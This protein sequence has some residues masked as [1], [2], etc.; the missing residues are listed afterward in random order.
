MLWWT[1]RV[2]FGRWWALLRRHVLCN[3]K[4]QC[5]VHA[6]P[7]RWL[8][9]VYP[10]LDHNHQHGRKTSN[11]VVAV[12]KARAHRG[13]HPDPGRRR[14]AGR[15]A[16]VAFENGGGTK[17]SHSAT[18]AGRHPIDVA[19]ARG[20]VVHRG[21]PGEEARPAPDEHVH[22]DAGHLLLELPF[23]PDQGRERRGAAYT[24][25]NVPLAGV[26]IQRHFGSSVVESKMIV[27]IVVRLS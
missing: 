6:P 3:L 4:E 8:E 15:L 19:Q 14:E 18:N 17:E 27:V 13:D 10:V 23:E 26:G 12:P 24:R 22:A 5:L 11:H 7:K 9:K 2:C 20:D 21:G 25:H 1:S 16:A